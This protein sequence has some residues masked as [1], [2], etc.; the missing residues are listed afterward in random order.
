[1]RRALQVQV[2]AFS[3]HAQSLPC[4]RPPIG[5]FEAFFTAQTSISGMYVCTCIYIHMFV[6]FVLIAFHGKLV[7]V[8]IFS[9]IFA[10]F[11][12]FQILSGNTHK[13]AIKRTARITANNN[14]K[15]HENNNKLLYISTTSYVCL[16]NA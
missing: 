15:Q 1:M 12:S 5:H 6:K 4:N 7:Q 13:F 16:S 11:F 9:L 14:R 10:Y 8:F 2:I 3:A